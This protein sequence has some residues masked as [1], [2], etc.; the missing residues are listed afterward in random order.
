L[1][2]PIPVALISVSAEVLAERYVAS[3]LRAMFDAVSVDVPGGAQLDGAELCARALA[4]ANRHA[5]NALEVLEEIIGEVMSEAPIDPGSA[6]LADH[7]RRRINC[8]LAARG[9]AY[10]NG[11]IVDCSAANIGAFT[12]GQRVGGGAYGEVFRATD[13]FGREVA[14]KFMHE[15]RAELDVIVG[16]ARALARANHPAVVTL[17]TVGEAIHP[18]TG[19]TMAVIAMELLDGESLRTWL[20]TNEPSDASV[21]SWSLLL[22]DV[23]DTLHSQRAFH[24]D[25]HP[26]NLC[27]T[28]RGLRIIDILYRASIARLSTQS[29]DEHARQDIREARLIIAS[30]L[31]RSQNG[32]ARVDTFQ[33]ETA[34]FHV[35]TKALRIALAQALMSTKTAAAIDNSTSAVFEDTPAGTAGPYLAV[36]AVNQSRPD[37]GREVRAFM[38]RFCDQLSALD[39]HALP[40]DPETNLRSAVDAT[41]PLIAQFDELASTVAAMDSQSGIDGIVKG[42]ES[43]LA[44]YNWPSGQSGSYKQYDFDLFRFLGHEMSVMLLSRL[45]REERTDMIAGLFEARFHCLNAP[46]RDKYG[47]SSWDSLSAPVVLWDQHRTTSRISIR[48]DVLNERHGGP[49]ASLV[50]WD[51]FMNAEFLLY[52]GL[53]D[54]LPWSYVYMR[55]TPRVLAESTHRIGARK[56]RT[57]L[58][59]PDIDQLRITAEL[60]IQGIAALRRQAGVPFARAIQFDTSHIANE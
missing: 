27:V 45:L 25:L 3:Q 9:L 12:V 57:M 11:R 38:A 39:P 8:A 37:A 5:P 10:R 58:R 60:R 44:L 14:L 16:H 29:F 49:L 52:L 40:G 28:T 17:Y 47:L 18:T 7:R 56:L 32:V 33:S 34:E 36:R 42:F 20:E 31:R 13:A 41:V 22:L 24:G 51:E 54:W 4:W 35:P 30:L 48:A 59:L 1:P 6:A 26:D 46:N 21:E 2:S 55:D 50:S 19:V 15:D 43:L 53:K 23:L